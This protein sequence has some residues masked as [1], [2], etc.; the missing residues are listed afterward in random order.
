[1]P[2]HELS[3]LGLTETH[4]REWRDYFAGGRMFAVRLD[5]A[6]ARRRLRANTVVLVVA[7]LVLLAAS[8]TFVAVLVGQLGGPV[9]VLLLALLALAAGV[10]LVR[11]A[12]LRR[13]LG[14]GRASGDDY[15]VVSAEGL[16]VA[17]HVDLPWTSIIGGVGYDD[18]GGAVPFL[19][20]PAAAVERAAGRM[21]SEYTIGVRG[22]RALR[23]AAPREMHGIFE[24]IAD[25]GGIR[26]P[27]DTMVAPENVRAALAAICIAGRGA[28]VDIEV[29]ADR[30]TI[31]RRTVALLGPE[32]T[33]PPRAE[34]G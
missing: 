2:V 3:A 11:F 29:T 9:T 8:T 22:V 19:R 25:H 17:E 33:A 23:D 20:A 10:L 18:R 7:A 1:M 27:L 24:V 21:Q 14:I 26:L 30:S 5:R 6:A 34:R 12:L 16:R 15:L 4:E 32:T 13:R 28:G 31:F